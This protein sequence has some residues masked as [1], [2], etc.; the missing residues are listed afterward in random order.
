M[1]ESNGP[2]PVGG[3]ERIF[4]GL[5]RKLKSEIWQLIHFDFRDMQ[6]RRG[7]MVVIVG[8]VTGLFVWTIPHY[9]S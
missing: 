2:T 5:T 4:D 1:L 7:I 9:H 3:N 6:P 8:F